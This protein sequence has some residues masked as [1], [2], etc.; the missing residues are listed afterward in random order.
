M[1][2]KLNFKCI[3]LRNNSSKLL[4][5]ISSLSLRI[6]TPRMEICVWSHAKAAALLSCKKTNENVENVKCCALCVLNE[7]TAAERV[8]RYHKNHNNDVSTLSLGIESG[9]AWMSFNF[10]RFPTAHTHQKAEREQHTM[11]SI[12]RG[13]TIAGPTEKCENLVS[14]RFFFMFFLIDFCSL[15]SFSRV[16]YEWESLWLVSEP[17]PDWWLFA[18][19]SWVQFDGGE[20]CKWRQRNVAERKRRKKGKLFFEWLWSRFLVH[21]VNDW[22]GRP[23]RRESYKKIKEN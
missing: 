17:G 6:Y 16:Y 11:E 12:K 1:E 5:K 7:K 14:F 18:L 23:I 15:V 9:I 21:H 13:E 22:I 3:H 8:F 10:S 2:I 19:Y 4:V 20:M